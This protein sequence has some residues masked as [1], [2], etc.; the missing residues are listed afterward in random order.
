MSLGIQLGKLDVEFTSEADLEVRSR[1]GIVDISGVGSG[2][3]HSPADIRV[4]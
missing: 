4:E 3:S 1:N 2:A